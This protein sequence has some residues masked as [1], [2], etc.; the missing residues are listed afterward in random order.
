MVGSIGLVTV[1]VFVLIWSRSFMFDDAAM[2]LKDGHYPEAASKLRVIASMGDLYAL[3]WRVPK[4]DD[5]AIAWCRRGGAGD[6]NVPDTA[7]PAMYYI[8]RKYLG[9]KRVPR[10]DA[11]ARKWPERSAQGGFTKPNRELT[12]LQ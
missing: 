9:A 10:N 7:A 1:I 6:E 2:A 12:R 5:E 11:E 4:N 3:G 8:A